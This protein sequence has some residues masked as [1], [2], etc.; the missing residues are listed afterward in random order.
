MALKPTIYKVELDLV[1]T[2]RHIYEN[3]KLTVALHPSENFRAYDGAVTCLCDET[4]IGIWNLPVACRRQR[5]RIS[6]NNR[7]MARSNTGLKWGR[8]ARTGYVKQ[9]SRAPKISL[10]AYG[11]EADIWW[12]KHQNAFAGLPK[13]AVWKLDWQQVQQLPEFESRTMVMTLT[14]TDGELYLSSD[15]AQLSLTAEALQSA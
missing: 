2:D 11:S 14:I 12:Q 6:G 4:T 8:P 5:K 1:D 9:V 7:R 15:K 3:L 13:V 10:Y